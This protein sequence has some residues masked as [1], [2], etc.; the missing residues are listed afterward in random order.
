LSALNVSGL[1][2]NNSRALI[3]DLSAVNETSGFEQHG[4]LGGDYLS[5][6]LV[7]IDLRRY[8]LKLTPQTKAITLAADAAP[9]K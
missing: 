9:E 3:L 2:K 8:Q 6:F 7:K 4:I 5:H 1:R